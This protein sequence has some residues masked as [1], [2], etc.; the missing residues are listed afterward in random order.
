M[1][2]KK[3]TVTKQSLTIKVATHIE[4]TT[5]SNRIR[6]HTIHAESE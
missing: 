4:F 5:L 6:G 1:K 2:M 3:L